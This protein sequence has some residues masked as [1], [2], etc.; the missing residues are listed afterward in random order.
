MISSVPALGPGLVLAPHGIPGQPPPA[1]DHVQGALRDDR[2]QEEEMTN[3]PHQGG[4]MRDELHQRRRRAMRDCHPQR[5]H[6]LVGRSQALQKDWL[7]N[8]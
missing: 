1:I 5:G 4:V 8:Y 3:G 6:P 2:H 7:R